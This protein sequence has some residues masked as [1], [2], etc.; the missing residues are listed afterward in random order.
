[1]SVEDL[2]TSD[3]IAQ[4]QTLPV[5]ETSDEEKQGIRLYCTLNLKKKQLI[6]DGIEDRKV[7]KQEQAKHRKL[8]LE[9][10]QKNNIEIMVLS[11][12]Q[13]K[14]LETKT[15]ALDIPMV[16]MFVRMIRNTKDIPVTVDIINEA[17][18]AVAVQDVEEHM[19]K[20]NLTFPEALQAVVLSN[21]R[22]TIRSYRFTLKLT[23]IKERSLK[24]YDIP[25]CTPEIMNSM[26]QL[27]AAT[28]K[29]QSKSQENKELISEITKEIQNKKQYV[30]SFFDRTGIMSQRIVM[31]NVPYRLVKKVSVTHEKIGLTKLEFWLSNSLSNLKSMTDFERD[32][33]KI[34]N[35]I[36][37]TIQNLPPITKSDIQ[38]C[39]VK[40]AK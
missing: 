40:N 25:E 23:E 10:L 39:S 11:K 26:F 20:M 13:F 29:L 33:Q 36:M 2:K 19:T 1:M 22:N 8:M 6:S 24:M 17:F 21:V 4:T 31:D 38:F 9:H 35:Q 18:D 3:L 7:L 27:H 14:E 16:P 15:A 30:Q 32:S 34:R 5:P 28:Y 12:D 37:K